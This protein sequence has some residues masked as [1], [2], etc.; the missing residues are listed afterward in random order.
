MGGYGEQKSYYRRA[1]A[2]KPTARLSGKSQ[3]STEYN[4]WKKV[5]FGRDSTDRFNAPTLPSSIALYTEAPKNGS[6]VSFLGW[7]RD[8]VD[9]VAR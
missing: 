3:K 1:I 4:A 5:A 6:P 9:D 8:Y 7:A 2:D